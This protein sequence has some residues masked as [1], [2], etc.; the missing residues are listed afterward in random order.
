MHSLS[1]TIGYRRA[2]AY[3]RST[4]FVMVV[5]A[6]LI[7]AAVF[8]ST[9]GVAARASADS[10][11][12]K[13]GAVRISPEMEL[14]AGVLAQTSWTRERG[15]T[16]Q[17]NEYYRALKEFMSSYRDHRAV[18]IAQT[19][20][21]RGFVFDAPIGFICHCGSLPD[22]NLEH[23][24]SQYLINRAG[25]R[26]ILEEFRSA[27]RDLARESRFL[28]FLKSWEDEFEQYVADATRDF[29]LE[30]M[31]TWLEGF[32]GWEA[33]EFHVILAPS[34]FPGGGYGATVTSR[35]GK[36]IAY[37]VVR[38]EG[39]SEGAPDL[40]SGKSLEKLT[41][42][43]L[44]HS[45]VNPTMEKYS[46]SVD[47]LRELF[48]PVAKQMREMAYPNVQ[49]F[50][51]EQVLRAVTSLAA[52]DLYGEAEYKAEIESHKGRGFYLTEV[53]A[54]ELEVYRAARDKYADF[55]DFVPRLLADLRQYQAQDSQSWIERMLGGV[56]TWVNKEALLV[57][58]AIL[59]GAGLLLI[60]RRRAT[61]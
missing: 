40:P 61:A 41:L 44:G 45:F 21:S 32:F 12:D 18:E 55:E 4:S 53:V 30:E 14:L 10:G 22:L 13:L 1:R 19:L 50:M 26:E 35:D 39:K 23:E 36:L 57:V 42:H 37:E 52:R 59:L 17:G 6:A 31:V 56:A 25:G 47:G 5:I 2:H 24:Y 8:L 34:M 38:A 3:L 16:G 54:A 7:A 28:E 15:P 20:T 58:G 9:M 11:A 33:Q 46:V 43:E 27:L 29:R 49:V 48:H 60:L 51:N